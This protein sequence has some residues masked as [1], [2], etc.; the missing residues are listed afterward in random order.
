MSKMLMVRNPKTGKDEIHSVQNGNDLVQHCGWSRTKVVHVQ[1][2]M[3][4]DAQDVLD[5]A[6][7]MKVGDLDKDDGESDKSVSMSVAEIAK[8]NAEA[9]KAAKSAQRKSAEGKLEDKGEKSE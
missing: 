3:D 8:M 7:Q 6:K 5:K 4:M 9:A 2:G 1:D